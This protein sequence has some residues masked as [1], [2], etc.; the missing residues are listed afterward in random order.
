MT[1]LTI[2]PVGGP[3][4]AAAMGLD[5]GRLYLSSPLVWGCLA[6]GLALVLVGRLWVARLVAH[7]MHGP[8]LS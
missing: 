7:A 1:I 8:M 2:L 5:L 4:L 3:L 6:A